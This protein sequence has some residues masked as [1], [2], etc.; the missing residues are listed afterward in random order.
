MLKRNNQLKNQ[1]LVMDQL[2]KKSV[3]Q[4]EG[5][6]RLRSKAY[7]KH[8]QFSHDHQV[9]LVKFLQWEVR[10]MVIITINILHDCELEWSFEHV[11]MSHILNLHSLI[12]YGSWGTTKW[13]RND[14]ETTISLSFVHTLFQNQIM[15]GFNIDESFLNWLPI[16]SNV[17]VFIS[18]MA[19]TWQSPRKWLLCFYQY[20]AIWKKLV[21]WCPLFIIKRTNES[22]LM[23]IISLYLV[24]K[25][26]QTLK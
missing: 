22:L 25:N 15:I 1:A 19:S 26:Q 6:N 2:E 13:W 5:D 16:E 10:N 12:R 4:L 18:P 9:Q 11:E 14:E 7:F 20:F 23:S 8:I 3:E 24:F 17:Y 21:H